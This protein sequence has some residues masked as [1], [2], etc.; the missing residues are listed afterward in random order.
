MGDHIFYSTKDEIASLLGL[1]LVVEIISLFLL[2]EK[3]RTQIFTLLV[4]L[5]RI[6]SLIRMQSGLIGFWMG[7]PIFC[8]DILHRHMIF[9]F[10][11]NFLSNVMRYHLI[12]IFLRVKYILM[13]LDLLPLSSFLFIF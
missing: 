12:F 1:G 13:L 8:R 7:D 6:L 9:K 5:Q 4:S 2:V 11:I 10:F 3:F